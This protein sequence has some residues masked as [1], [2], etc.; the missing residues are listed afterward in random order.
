METILFLWERFNMPTLSAWDLRGINNE[1]KVD[2]YFIFCKH[3]LAVSIF[4]ETS[5]QY[6]TISF[7]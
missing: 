6:K 4:S 7:L 5:L 1:K 3:D 2:F